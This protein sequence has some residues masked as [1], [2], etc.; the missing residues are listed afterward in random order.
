M[1]TFALFV[2]LQKKLIVFLAHTHSSMF[3]L[4]YLLMPPIMAIVWYYLLLANFVAELKFG[5]TY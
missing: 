4:I 2:A 5:S 3:T 1:C